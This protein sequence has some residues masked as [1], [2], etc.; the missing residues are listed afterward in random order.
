M[1]VT[2]ENITGVNVATVNLE[3]IDAANAEVFKKDLCKILV[4]VKNTVLDLHKVTFMDSSGLG[5]LLSCIRYL[6]A[7][8]SSLK[9]CRVTDPVQ[10]ILELVRFHRIV[11]IYPSRE[12]ALQAFNEEVGQPA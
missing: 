1:T 8:E 7:H 6:A 12:E 2:L 3:E 5:A 4:P 10:A 11:D 9:M